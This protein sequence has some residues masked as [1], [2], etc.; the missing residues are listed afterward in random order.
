MQQLTERLEKT[1]ADYGIES[2]SDKSKIILTIIKPRPSTNI[3][4]NRTVL[5]EVDQFKCVR[6]TQTKD[7]TSFKEVT[8]RHAQALSA[9]KRLAVLWKNKAIIFPTKITL[10]KSLVLSILLF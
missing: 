1:A 9:M 2:S 5:E 4:M 6:C 8:I 7:G 10:N 3:R